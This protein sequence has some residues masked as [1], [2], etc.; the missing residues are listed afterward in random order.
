MDNSLLE[1]SPGLSGGDRVHII[2]QL[3]DIKERQYRSLLGLT[4]LVQVLKER[5]LLGDGEW[6]ARLQGLDREEEQRIAQ[7][8]WSEAPSKAETP[9]SSESRS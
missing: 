5:G 7:A 1:E 4:A 2:A 8:C 9:S 3:A 6:Q